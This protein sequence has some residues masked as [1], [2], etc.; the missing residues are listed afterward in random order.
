MSLEAKILGL[1][2]K[3]DFDDGSISNV[4]RIELP[5]GVIVVALVT[6]QGA[7]QMLVAL[8]ASKNVFRERPALEVPQAPPVQQAAPRMAFAPRP[9]V[10][11]PPQFEFGGSSAAEES[12]EEEEDEPIVPPQLGPQLTRVRTP[13]ADDAGNPTDA[14]GRP[15][16]ENAPAQEESRTD[17]DG[18]RGL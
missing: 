7:Q 18:V 1:D 4:A 3:V 9:A 2:Q 5:G 16:Y 8:Q 6:E 10:A 14:A 13:A 11:P 17:E 15:L 12:F